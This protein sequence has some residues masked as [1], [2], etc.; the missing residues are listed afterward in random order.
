MEVAT[1]AAPK[2]DQPVT[3]ERELDRGT[4]FVRLRPADAVQNNVRDKYSFRVRAK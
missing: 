4:Y 2:S 3:L 1:A